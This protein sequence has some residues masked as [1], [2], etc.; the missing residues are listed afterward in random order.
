MLK[1]KEYKLLLMSCQLRPKCSFQW[2]S[3]RHRWRR[4]NWIILCG[5]SSGNNYLRSVL[6]WTCILH[7]PLENTTVLPITRPKAIQRTDK[8][9]FPSLVVWSVVFLVIMR[10][11]CLNSSSI[12]ISILDIQSPISNGRELGQILF[13]LQKL[14]KEHA[15]ETGLARTAHHKEQTNAKS[16]G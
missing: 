16:K 8:S 5:W 1:R 7:P 4:L 10:K 11:K 12:S 9:S 15:E 3:S 14:K 6:T 2:T 13:F